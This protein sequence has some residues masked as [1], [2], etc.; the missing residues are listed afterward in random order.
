MLVEKD[1]AEKCAKIRRN[2]LPHS[3]RCVTRQKKQ[4]KT[5]ADPNDEPEQNNVENPEKEQIQN[6]IQQKMLEMNNEYIE[7]DDSD[8][9]DLQDIFN[10]NDSSDDS[11]FEWLDD[12]AQLSFP[13][14]STSKIDPDLFQDGNNGISLT[15]NVAQEIE[16]EKV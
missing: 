2:I 16:M 11:G 14:P 3:Y 7:L 8:I 15:A 5:I 9:D 10:G 13:L 12:N 4:Y 6:E 1:K